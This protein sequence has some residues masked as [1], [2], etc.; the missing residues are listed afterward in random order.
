MGN[1]TDYT[2]DKALAG[3]NTNK[4]IKVNYETEQPTVSA[5]DL[6]HVYVLLSKNG[7]VK[8]GV[9]KNIVKRIAAIEGASG[10][11]IEDYYI[12]EKCSN[13]YAIE[14][15][16]HEYFRNGRLFGEWFNI[17]FNDAINVVKSLYEKHYKI[18]QRKA[19]ENN[20]SRI[21]EILYP[22]DYREYEFS[23]EFIDLSIAVAEKMKEI[24]QLREEYKRLERENQYLKKSKNSI[25]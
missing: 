17:D 14:H 5:R 23:D 13:S 4:I 19:E 11:K 16:A 9:S 18:L 3:E 25:Q 6:K 15:M 24:R 1:I 22:K 20:I 8:I 21:I 7:N 12:T 10:Y 2:T